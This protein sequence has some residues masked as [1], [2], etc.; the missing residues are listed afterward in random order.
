GLTAAG[1]AGR[2]SADGR[3][4]GR[5]NAFKHGLCAREVFPEEMAEEVRREEAALGASLRPSTALERR[6]V[7]QAAVGAV[8]LV[9]S[10]AAVEAD[11]QHRV[12]HATRDW[13]AA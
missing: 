4:P 6:L 3:L 11:T 7:T 2:K 9:R 1:R 13:D 10:T 12:R 5:R 8:R